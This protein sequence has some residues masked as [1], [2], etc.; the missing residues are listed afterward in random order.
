MTMPKSAWKARRAQLTIGLDS[1]TVMFEQFVSR[2][3]FV[4]VVNSRLCH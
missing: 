4:G 1:M 2:S 3:G